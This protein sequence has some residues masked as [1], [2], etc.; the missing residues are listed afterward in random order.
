MKRLNML[1]RVMNQETGA[2]HDMS[3]YEYFKL[4]LSLMNVRMKT[5]L[6][7]REVETLAAIM[8]ICPT[9]DAFKGVPAQRVRQKIGMKSPNY[10]KMK[11][12]L[13]AKGYVIDGV[14]HKGLADM[15]V[16][17]VDGDYIELVYNVNIINTI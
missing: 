13:E 11:T 7:P 10:L 1:N 14:L 4:F 17:T 8:L 9:K 15:A 3:A 2:S 6:T 5:K 12:I 16:Y